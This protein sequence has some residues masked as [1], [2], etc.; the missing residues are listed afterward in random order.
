MQDIREV[1]LS[2]IPPG[3]LGKT[4]LMVVP[5]FMKY[6]LQGPREFGPLGLSVLTQNANLF[7]GEFYCYGLGVAFSY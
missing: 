5:L 4:P 3:L 2:Q 1:G 7:H 6:R